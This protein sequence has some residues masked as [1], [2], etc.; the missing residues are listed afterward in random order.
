MTGFSAF[1]QQ[2]VG[3]RES[4]AR[5]SAP[6]IDIF[7]NVQRNLERINPIIMNANAGGNGAFAGT[8]FGPVVAAGQ[9]A[10]GGIADRVRITDPDELRNVWA[11]PTATPEETRE[12]QN[13]DPTILG[14]LGSFGASPLGFLIQRGIRDNI[15]EQFWSTPQRVGFFAIGFVMLSIGVVFIAMPAA[16]A[17]GQIALGAR[18]F[19]AAGAVQKRVE[20]GTRKASIQRDPDPLRLGGDDG[21]NDPRPN[22]GPDTLEGEFTPSPRITNAARNARRAGDTLPPILSGEKRDAPIIPPREKRV[23]YSGES[24]AAPRPEKSDAPEAPKIVDLDEAARQADPKASY[25]AENDFS[26][27]PVRA[28]PIK[29]DAPKSAMKHVRR[30][31]GKVKMRV[32]FP[33]GRNPTVTVAKRPAGKDRGRNIFGNLFDP[34]D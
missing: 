34:K 11:M 32:K 30:K 28:A 2:I 27:E 1:A 6:I 24:K 21:A 16:P 12:A 23:R 10:A 15:V 4:V 25:K 18:L 8:F 19:T 13:T 9:A 22:F 5:Y 31:D 7:E 20:R 33:D 3:T 29:K 14:D 26:D 17:I